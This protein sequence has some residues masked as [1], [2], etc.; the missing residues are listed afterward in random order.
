MPES[1]CQVAD[2]RH[3]DAIRRAERVRSLRA[4]GRKP[5]P[6]GPG[7]VPA[8][9]TTGVRGASLERESDGERV[10]RLHILLVA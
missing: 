6:G 5:L 1:F 2:N 4:V 7:I 8:G 3:P 10:G 9:I